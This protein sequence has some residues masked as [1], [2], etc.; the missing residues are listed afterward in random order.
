MDAG[1]SNSTAPGPLLSA[2]NTTDS[3]TIDCDDNI[4]NRMVCYCA[5]AFCVYLH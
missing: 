5:D 2:D 4:Q 3:Q 1:S